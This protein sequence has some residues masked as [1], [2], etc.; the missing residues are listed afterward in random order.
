METI[1][2]P[3]K[4]KSGKA[5]IPDGAPI[6]DSTI[7]TR[8][9]RDRLRHESQTLEVAENALMAQIKM[10]APGDL[11]ENVLQ[12]AHDKSQ[13]A[14]RLV[15]DNAEGIT[16]ALVNRALDGDIQAAQLL[17]N[18]FLPERKSLLKFKVKES[19]DQTAHSILEATAEGVMDAESA[20]KA[21]TLLE[22]AGS[23]AL[24]GAIV[25]RI[26]TLR[27]QI[28]AFSANQSINV[29]SNYEIVDMGGNSESEGA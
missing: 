20:S 23:V 16:Q 28:Q 19:A 10:I 17:I 27:D 24:S 15:I 7:R 13:A 5:R 11:P 18:R 1:H 3:S 14:L 29:A 8:A 4:K 26:N 2:I 12:D 9:H 25:S 21:L 6:A 22:K